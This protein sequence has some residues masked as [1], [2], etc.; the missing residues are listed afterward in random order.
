M[1]ETNYTGIQ[2]LE[3]R[4]L[5]SASAV[6]HAGALRVK[7]F[8]GQANVITIANSADASA[9]DVTVD[10]VDA[11]GTPHN[12][13]KSFPKA[14]GISS[15]FVV[16]SSL[17]DTISVGQA[18][19]TLGLE[20]FDLP[21]TVISG[22]GDDFITTSDAN[23]LVLPGAGNDSVATN[24]GDDVVFAG[25]G[26]DEVDA[27]DGNDW[28]RG[29]VGNDAINGGNGDDRLNGGF[30]ND[31]VQGGAGNDLLRGEAGDDNLDGGGGNDAIFGGL[32]NDVLRGSG[33][34]DALWGSFGDDN[35][36]GGAGN[37]SLGG[38]IGRNALTGGTGADTFHVRALVLNSSNDYTPAEGDVL[39]LVPKARG[40][41][42]KPPAA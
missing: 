2:P 17:R 24:G 22:A 23:D 31:A 21:T 41:G 34:D 36:D 5:M 38:I 35:L 28:V 3:G 26:D 7:G 1:F 42:P 30:G 25:A 18:N 12:L 4:V 29:M 20:G 40:E 27:G 39:D 11:A 16:G 13:T 10:S 33:G 32:G 15:I 9:I 14:M 19:D 37:D 8:G 6:F